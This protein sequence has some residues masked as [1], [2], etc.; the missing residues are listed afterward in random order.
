[1]SSESGNV[2]VVA[3]AKKLIMDHQSTLDEHRA[4][5]FSPTL[6]PIYV[7]TVLILL[8]NLDL[9]LTAKSF[10]LTVAFEKKDN[11]FIDFLLAHKQ[12]GVPEI[13]K[14]FRLLDAK[15]KIR[16][17][18]KTI[19]RLEKKLTKEDLERLREKQRLKKKNAGDTMEVDP[20]ADDEKDVKDDTTEKKT[21]DTSA[22]SD[23]KSTSTT[24]TT[25]TT[26][27]AER[28]LD[29]MVSTTEEVPEDTKEEEA[30]TDEQRKVRWNAQRSRDTLKIINQLRSKIN[31][32]SVIQSTLPSLSGAAARKVRKWIK[33]IPAKT[34]A[35]YALTMP[36]E[37]WRELADIVHLRKKDFQLEW[38]LEVAFGA[39]PPADSIL[40]A[41]SDGINKD[42]INDILE[43]HEWPYTY[44]RTSMDI[45]DLT[46]DMKAKISEY[47][48]IS[49]LIWWYEE[50]ACYPV[51]VIISRRLRDGHE[52][53]SFGYG[54]MMERIMTFQT[55]G[56]LFYKDLI[57]LTVEKLKSFGY[58]LALDHP[59]NVIGDASASMQEAIKT[60]KI[61]S[62]LLTALTPNARLGF[63][64]HA[65]I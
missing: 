37:P 34:L 29:K 64:N 15:R 1:M 5:F 9:S 22:S 19:I 60:S 62:S 59:L 24:T 39:P 35:F 26:T 40:A 65:P 46:D 3:K 6:S 53:P 58:S 48:D 63:F 17:I 8:E 10:I 27:E 44:I 51:D 47:E 2:D 7:S 50:L 32:L 33:A 54:K 30:E 4:A 43:K 42:N 16:Q 52:K 49:I 14:T 45:M 18:E 13:L 56:V 11:T 21:G 20:S 38:F 41:C 31:D 28:F 61:I 55:A 57:P 23:D 12:Y 36:K 25:T